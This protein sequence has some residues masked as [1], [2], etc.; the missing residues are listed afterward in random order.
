M[1]QNRI[2]RKG[3]DLILTA[4]LVL[5]GLASVLTAAGITDCGSVHAAEGGTWVATSTPSY[6]HPV[7]GAIEDSG[8]NE[9]IGQGMTESVL[10]RKAL[11]E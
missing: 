10:Y 8:A 3:L 4:I 1:Y 7:T 2:Y 9:S 5:A 6:K 11:I